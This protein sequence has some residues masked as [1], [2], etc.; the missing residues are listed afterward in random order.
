M[1]FGESKRDFL[2]ALILTFCVGIGFLP[3]ESKIFQHKFI[4]YWS[5]IT[6]SIYLLHDAFRTFIFPN[7]IGFPESIGMRLVYALLYMVVVT[8]S[9]MLFDLV[10]KWLVK[11]GKALVIKV[12]S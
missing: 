7:V 9:A 11:K 2:Y 5:G 10:I 1:V 3:S 8:V 4:H 6:L 12:V